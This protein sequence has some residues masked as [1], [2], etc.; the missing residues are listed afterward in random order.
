MENVIG[1]GLVAAVCSFGRLVAFDR[2]RVFYPTVVAVLATHYILFAL[3]GGSTPALASEFWIAAL[4]FALAVIGFK[5]NLWLGCGRG[6]DTQQ[7]LR[8]FSRSV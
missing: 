3:M 1:V 5:K 4:F 6:Q 7:C 8:A 2:D